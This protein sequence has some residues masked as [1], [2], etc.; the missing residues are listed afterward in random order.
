M[1]ICEILYLCVGRYGQISGFSPATLLPNFGQLSGLFYQRGK[2][3]IF[4]IEGVTKL[5][6]P[7]VDSNLLPTPFRQE[8]LSGI[9][10]HRVRSPWCCIDKV[11]VVITSG[12]T[13]ANDDRSRVVHPNHLRWALKGSYLTILT[14]REA[15]P[16][17]EDGGKI[18]TA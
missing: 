14:R 15:H 6:L 8:R 1:K 16:F 11:T 7:P 13:I 18:L 5:H 2:F 12:N 9:Y 10:S 4:P 17:F 3:T